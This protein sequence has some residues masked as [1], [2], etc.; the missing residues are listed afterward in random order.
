MSQHPE[1]AV[2]ILSV[3][4]L[5]P[6]VCIWLHVCLGF[7]LIIHF[8]FYECL[9]HADNS[10]IA[11]PGFPGST[12]PLQSPFFL[13]VL[14]VSHPINARGNS[15]RVWKG[16]RAGA[17]APETNIYHPGDKLAA[18]KPGVHRFVYF[19]GQ[20]CHSTENN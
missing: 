15:V 14:H 18:S 7:F 17:R 1:E 5:F 9:R 10:D 8:I 12:F 19:K 13:S 20:N 4:V 3:G 2:H 6:C 11:H 16:N